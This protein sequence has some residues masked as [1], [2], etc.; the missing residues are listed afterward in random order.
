MFAAW[1]PK[2]TG[3]KVILDIHDVVP[4]LFG[5]KF[6]ANFESAYVELLKAIEKLSADFADHVIV[7]N[8]LWHEKIVAC[9]VS[10]ERSSVFINHVDP[11]MFARR[12]KNRT[13][14]K[15]VIL[16]PG[17]LQWHQGVDI[18]IE[19]FARVKPRIPNAEF[20]I[21]CG[22]GVIQGDLQ[23][24]TRKPGSRG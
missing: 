4:E 19:A 13:D 9:S 17:S 2:L 20:H 12:A 8:H 18:A 5:N 1:Y 23:D 10:Q 7:S 24:L 14:D 16:F 11:K 22:S 6:R 21:Y 3:A 15:F